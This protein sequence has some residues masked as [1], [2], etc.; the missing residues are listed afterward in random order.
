MTHLRDDQV[1]EVKRRCVELDEDLVLTDF[2]HGGFAKGQA[3]ETLV[4]AGDEPLLHGLGGHCRL[5]GIEMTVVKLSGREGHGIYI[6]GLLDVELHRHDEMHL[7]INLAGHN[8]T[9]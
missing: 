3:V 6:L 8:L 5:D 4:L 1:A 2:G 7:L 9:S